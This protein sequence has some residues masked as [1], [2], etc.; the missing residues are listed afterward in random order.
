MNAR[1][2]DPLPQRITVV[3]LT[4]NRA[5]ELRRTL[6]R[7]LALPLQPLIMVVD[8]GS[9]DGTGELMKSRFPYIRLIT[10]PRNIGAAARNAGVRLAD[11]DYVAFCDDDTWWAGGS[12]ER[13]VALLDAHPDLAVLCARVLVGPEERED[14]TCAG[15]AASPLP[16]EGLPGPALLGFMAGASVFRR[17]AFLEAGGYEPKLFI[18][19]EE[20]L[21]TLD[22]AARGWRLAYI[23]QMTV[24]HYPSLQRDSGSRRKYLARNALWVCWMRLPLSVALVQTWRILGAARRDGVLGAGLAAALRGLPWVMRR[25]KVVPPAV[26]HQYRILHG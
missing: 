26:A 12:L 15:M 2:E 5:D 17:S 9:A 23:P 14:P 13:A 6:E 1:W 25:R 11:T 20:T 7:M 21:L 24:H 3:V 10:L 18:G 4:H 19:G 16:S 22:L 8:N